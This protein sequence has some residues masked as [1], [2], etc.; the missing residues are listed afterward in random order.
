MLTVS[1]LE[2]IIV[3]QAFLALVTQS[4]LQKASQHIARLEE[5]NKALLEKVDEQGRLLNPQPSALP[6]DR[7][8][9]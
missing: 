4:E 8:L 1:N 5:N 3:H 7:E 9:S 2:Q 6:V